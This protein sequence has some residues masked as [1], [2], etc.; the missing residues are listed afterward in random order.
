MLPRNSKTFPYFQLILP[1]SLGW[2]RHLSSFLA[3]DLPSYLPENTEVI[4]RELPLSLTNQHLGSHNLPPTN[5]LHCSYLT[6]GQHRHLRTRS[7]STLPTQGLHPC[8]CLFSLVINCPSLLHQPINLQTYYNV[9]PSKNKKNSNLMIF[10]LQPH[11]SA[12]LITILKRISLW[13]SIFS[14]FNSPL[15]FSFVN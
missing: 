14:V 9:C 12:L 8:K 4:R 15:I 2:I 10:Q 11:Y 13:L 1:H 6:W 3:E 5:C 7:H